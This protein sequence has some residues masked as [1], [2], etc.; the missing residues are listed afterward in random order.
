MQF[1][2]GMHG[3]LCACRLALDLALRQ[4]PLYYKSTGVGC[5]AFV[6]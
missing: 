1:S 3:V 5:N 2:K 4:Q 6:I